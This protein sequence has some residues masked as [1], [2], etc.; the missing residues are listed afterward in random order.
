MLTSQNTDRIPASVRETTRQLMAKNQLDQVIA[1]I[2]AALRN[3]QPQPW[4]YESLG[5]AM[6][7]KGSS[8]SEIERTIMSAADFSTSAN[9]L[10]YVAQYLSRLGLDR[11]AMLV[12]QQVAKVAPLRSEAYVLRTALGARSRRHRRYPLGHHRHS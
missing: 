12:C 10:M 11:R 2:N 1:L 8:K 5:I 7:L 3:G 9:E 4:M 6:E